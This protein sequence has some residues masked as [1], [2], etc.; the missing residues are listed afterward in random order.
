MVFFYIE[1]NKNDKLKLEKVNSEIK[2]KSAQ[3]DK[4]STKED[5]I[6][7]NLPKRAEKADIEAERLIKPILENEKTIIRDTT[8]DFMYRYITK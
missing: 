1:K 3:I 5:N 8:D 2:G 7:E 4:V 6:L